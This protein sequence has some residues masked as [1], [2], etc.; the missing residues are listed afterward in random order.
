MDKVDNEIDKGIVMFFD[1]TNDSK[2][3]I[4][5]KYPS[6]ETS[7]IEDKIIVNQESADATIAAVT[8]IPAEERVEVEVQTEVEVQ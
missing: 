2:I 8:T 1:E 5:V 3:E 4:N 7:L 6:R